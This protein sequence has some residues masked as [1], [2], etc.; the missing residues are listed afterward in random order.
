MIRPGRTINVKVLWKKQ[1][2][3]NYF[4]CVCHTKG[5][6]SPAVPTSRQFCNMHCTP[7]L[8]P[9]RQGHEGHYP[10]RGHCIQGLSSHARS[11]PCEFRKPTTIN[12]HAVRGACFCLS[13]KHSI[14]TDWCSLVPM[15]RVNYSSSSFKILWWFFR[16]LGLMKSIT[17]DH[18]LVTIESKAYDLGQNNSCLGFRVYF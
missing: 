11:R 14:F 7:W 6:E 2:W 17:W 10:H 1:W 12:C 13:A 5:I 3:P 9:L 8:C 15:N 16:A 18:S 4:P